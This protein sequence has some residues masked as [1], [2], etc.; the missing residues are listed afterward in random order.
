MANHKPFFALKP[1]RGMLI[2][3]LVFILLPFVIGLFD[4]ASPAQVWM[5]GS[6][7]S[8]FIQGL[9]I[10]IFILALYA[11]SYDLIF[12]FTGLLSFGH[13]MFFAVGAYLTGILLKNFGFSLAATF[14]MIFVASILQA[15]LFGMVLP[16][17]KGIT[18]ALVTL[19][20]ASVFHVLVLS[21]ELGKFTGSDV[22]LQGVV[23]PDFIS[24]AT[25]RLRLYFITLTI[26]VVVF[27]LYKRFVNSTT[28]R[29]CTAIRENEG[30]ALM[31]G[32]NTF[33]FKLAALMLSSLTAALAGMMH[34]IYQPIVSPNVAGLGF[35]VTALLIILIGGVGTLNG[36]IIGAVAYRLLDYGLR[37][38]IGESASFINGAVYVLIV[39]FLP[40]GIVGTWRMKSL[41]INQGWKRLLGMFTN[42]QDK[43]DGA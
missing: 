15:L 39:L 11:L 25:E 31:L 24:P 1:D 33:Y 21:T 22:G 10:E 4:G 18:F 7:Q 32:Y 19:G 43:S 13:S 5:N 41:Q 6:G 16:R 12:G 8:K 3:L 40:F 27:M 38:Y 30:R 37:R 2:A 17:V 20:M 14:G 34:S 23:V 26:L 36:A 9:A 29:V 28:G 35:T 42:S